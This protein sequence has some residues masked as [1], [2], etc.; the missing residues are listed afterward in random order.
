MTVDAATRRIVAFR[1]DDDGDWIAELECGHTIHMRHNPPWQTR[2]WVLT[3]E[4][5]SRMLGVTLACIQCAR[6]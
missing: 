1:L 2:P 6:S 3:E 4:G 5:R